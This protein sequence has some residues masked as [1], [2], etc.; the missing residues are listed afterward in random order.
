MYALDTNVLVRFLVN[1]DLTQA[2]QVHQFFQ[3]LEKNEQ[4]VM[5][6]VPVVLELCW[7]LKSRYFLSK[8]EIIAAVDDL[9]LLPIL[10]FEHENAIQ[11]FLL[12]AQTLNADL[13]DLLIAYVAQALNCEGV[14]TFDRKAQRCGLFKAIP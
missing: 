7:V 13:A 10:K 2:E 8:T 4:Q 12:E 6:P 11:S 5:V 1:D 9:M 14:W 3:K